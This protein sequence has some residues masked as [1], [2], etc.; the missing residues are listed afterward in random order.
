MI[1]YISP[2]SPLYLPCNCPASPLDLPYISHPSGLGEGDPAI[3]ARVRS[4]VR[5]AARV[6]VWGTVRARARVRFRVRVRIGHRLSGVRA[7]PD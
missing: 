7:T 3:I 1:P 2:V 4:P 6:L 5:V